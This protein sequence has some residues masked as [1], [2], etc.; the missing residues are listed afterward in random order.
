MPPSSRETYRIPH[1]SDDAARPET[2]VRFAGSFWVW[3]FGVIAVVV[4]I[5]HFWMMWHVR[6]SQT[7]IEVEAQ[8]VEIVLDLEQRLALYM[9]N[10]RYLSNPEQ[11]PM[12]FYQA[13]RKEQ[14]DLLERLLRQDEGDEVAR[15]LDRIDQRIIQ[16][17]GFE[18]WLRSADPLWE[19]VIH[20]FYT[21]SAHQFVQELEDSVQAIHSR[22]WSH[23]NVVLKNWDSIWLLVI[24]GA[25]LTGI[26]F[27]LFLANRGTIRQL[28]G[29][30]QALAVAN[31]SLAQEIAH[32]KRMQ[33]S[34]KKQEES[35]RR[36]FEESLSGNYI[37]T[38]DGRLLACNSVFA[39]IFGFASVEEARTYSMNTLYSPPVARDQFIERL[40]KEKSIQNLEVELRRLD[41]KPVYVT[42]N[43]FGEFD[44]AGRLLALRGYVVDDTR[45]KLLEEQLLQ[46]GKM[47]AVGR[48]A[49]G[50]AHDFNNMITAIVGYSNILMETV[51][52]DQKL[53]REGLQE[54][55]KAGERS[56]G[57]VRRLLSFSRNQV[58]VPRVLNLNE[59]VTDLEKMLRLLLG[60]HIDIDVQLSP[61]LKSIQADHGQIESVLLNMALNARDAMPNG[62][63]L[64]IRTCNVSVNGDEAYLKGKLNKG[65]YSLITV[66]DT[67]KG[68][69][70]SVKA[71]LF[72]PFFTTKGPGHGTGLGLAS[73]ADII[74]KAG[75]AILVDSEL[76]RGTMF[77]IYLPH[78]GTQPLA[79]GEPYSP[80]R[81]K[82]A[83]ADKTI[84]LVEDEE[85]VRS[86]TERVLKL[87][88]FRVLV[89][90]HGIEA[91]QI[92]DSAKEPIDILVTDI[93]LPQMNGY[94][95]SEQLLER[96]PRMLVMFMTGYAKDTGSRFLRVLKP[97]QALLRK[98]FS[99]D[100]LMQHIHS[101][102]RRETPPP[103]PP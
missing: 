65:E 33:D 89:A 100:T 23:R 46:S 48:L 85:S 10:T 73:A 15:L 22:L 13:W 84:L 91:L 88:G 94:Q 8:L 42:E 76:E 59:V 97:G 90:S 24:S 1:L 69:D 38:P 40:R 80:K 26:I 82:L 102:M 6:Q 70:D 18:Q 67:G 19:D 98:P 79:D 4:L 11:T 47:D 37:T 16:M 30:T 52:E 44:E 61:D 35:Y 17:A 29:Q 75:G 50:I 71:R 2:P 96:H 63:K 57:L 54:I 36:F 93:V 7:Y 81:V 95:L 43:V 3:A 62:G 92:F 53:V 55:I 12:D 14:G 45:R 86:F 60:E 74:Q 41:G 101:L 27:F 103:Q 56:A 99:P 87:Y 66:A 9:L 58:V 49:G 28:N 51:P 21:L 72:E 64:T 77:S 20:S 5:F 31:R 32:R 39:K 83:A 34:L 68:M 25:I 78:L